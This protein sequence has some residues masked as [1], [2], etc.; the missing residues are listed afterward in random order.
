MASSSGLSGRCKA[1]W[2]AQQRA[3]IVSYAYDSSSLLLYKGLSILGASSD[4]L[5]LSIKMSTVTGATSNPC[6]HM[7]GRCSARAERTLH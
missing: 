3:F 7:T 4:L 6:S 2:R 5:A 1:C